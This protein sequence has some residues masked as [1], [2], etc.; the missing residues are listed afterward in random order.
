MDQWLGIEFRNASSG[1][2]AANVFGSA[3]A[4][5]IADPEGAMSDAGSRA[6]ANREETFC[7]AS[8]SQVK[9]L[10]GDFIQSV[11]WNSTTAVSN[12]FGIPKS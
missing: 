10:Y 3:M 4:R 7:R 1:R 8:L 2:S 11:S 6:L 12:L 5:L 9:R